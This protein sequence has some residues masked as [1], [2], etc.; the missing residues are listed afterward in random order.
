MVMVRQKNPHRDTTI[1]M[2]IE[3]ETRMKRDL[4]YTMNKCTGALMIQNAFLF[5][6]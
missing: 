2:A 6:W 4:V 3:H 1:P 5:Q